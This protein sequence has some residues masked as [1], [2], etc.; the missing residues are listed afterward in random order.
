MILLA[1]PFHIILFANISSYYIIILSGRCIAS[2]CHPFL[3]TTR[4][5]LRLCRVINQCTIRASALY[6]K[7]RERCARVS[8][9]RVYHESQ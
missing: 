3:L 5:R 1:P 7:R 8:N 4:R 6:L 9:T 2:S